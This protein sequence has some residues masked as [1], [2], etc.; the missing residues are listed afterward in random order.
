MK[1]LL[2]C[3]M[4]TLTLSAC[5]ITKKDTI[6]IEDLY[7]TQNNV[8]KEVSFNDDGSVASYTCTDKTSGVRGVEGDKCAD[9]SIVINENN[10]RARVERGQQA[11]KTIGACL[12][13]DP[14]EC[15]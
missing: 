12:Y 15:L 6:A 8:D 10:S 13:D 4:V 11:I 7:V 2:I 14:T 1:K 5:T 9:V 3:L